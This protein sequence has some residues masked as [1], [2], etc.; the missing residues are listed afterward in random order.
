MGRSQLEDGLFELIIPLN[1]I[2]IKVFDVPQILDL[3]LALVHCKKG[4]QIF[5]LKFEVQKLEQTSHCSIDLTK[6]AGLP[7]TAFKLL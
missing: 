2:R 7:H 4:R 5:E 6:W 3:N 1:I